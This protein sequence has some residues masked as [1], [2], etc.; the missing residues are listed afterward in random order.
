M[1]NKKKNIMAKN[2][3]PFSQTKL[4]EGERIIL[5]VE[6]RDPEFSKYKCSSHIQHNV[7][8]PSQSN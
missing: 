2:G 1:L 4:I 3:I 8:N 5:A 6:K 7:R